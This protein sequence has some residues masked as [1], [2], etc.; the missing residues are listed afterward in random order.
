MAS[1][2]VEVPVTQEQHDEM[3]RAA[4]YEGLSLASWARATLLRIARG[5][6][7]D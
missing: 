6:T 5:R 7:N 3:K 2:K 4:Q 1:R